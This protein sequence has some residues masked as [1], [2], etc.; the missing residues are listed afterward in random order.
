MGIDVIVAETFII[1]C[2]G[3]SIF[4]GVF[5]AAAVIAVTMD[6]VKAEDGEKSDEDE[7]LDDAD[8]KGADKLDTKQVEHIHKE[9]LE[10]M[11]E[12]SGMIKDGAKSFL[13]KE[14]SYMIVFC[15]LFGLIIFFLAET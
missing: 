14:Y 4:F 15:I 2:S 5:N 1:I 10:H 11:L 12:L 8:K 7:L 6:E 13:F 3:L 9:K